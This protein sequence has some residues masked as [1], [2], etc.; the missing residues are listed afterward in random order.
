MIAL[1][2]D[3]E[4]TGVKSWD[5]PN[6]VPRLVQLGAILQD[7]ETGRVLGELNILNANV[8]NIPPEAAAVH[9]ISHEL[10]EKAGAQL[11]LVDKVFERMIFNA[12]VIIAHNI[13]YDLEVVKDNMPQSW[14]RIIARPH[15]CTMQG[16]LY[17]V[18]AEFSP[19][20]KALFMRK[21]H[22]KDAPYKIPNLTETHQYFFGRPFEG[23]HDAMADIRACRDIYL[24]LTKDGFWKYENG[25]HQMG[26]EIAKAMATI[27]K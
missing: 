17:L 4:T 10:A 5:N 14:E 23:A 18:K 12:D 1:F 22:L 21:P 8:G 11:L 6:F 25:A 13:K 3:T 15:F 26:P 7:M 2:F 19:K 24:E 9:G 20:Q 27:Q 16:S